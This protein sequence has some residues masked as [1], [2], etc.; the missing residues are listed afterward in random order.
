MIQQPVSLYREPPNSELSHGKIPTRIPTHA[1]QRR[2]DHAPRWCV[3]SQIRRRSSNLPPKVTDCLSRLGIADHTKPCIAG[4][5]Q[6]RK[7]IPTRVWPRPVYCGGYIVYLRVSIR[8]AGTGV[9]D[10]VGLVGLGEG[11]EEGY[12]RVRVSGGVI[13]DAKVEVEIVKGREEV[14]RMDAWSDIVLQI[15]GFAG[16]RVGEVADVA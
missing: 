6:P 16:I 10:E 13:E 7:F 2:L 8:I 12:Q 5:Q 15:V 14:K 1:N 4:V 3:P 9:R 11:A